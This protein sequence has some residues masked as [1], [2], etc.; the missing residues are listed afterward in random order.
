[1]TTQTLVHKAAPAAFPKNNRTLDW[2]AHN[3]T[4]RHRF[5]RVE[6]Q[7]AYLLNDNVTGYDQSEINNL[8][9]DL[10]AI[11]TEFVRLNGGLATMFARKFDSN[12]RTQQH[13]K[14]V[15][16]RDYHASAMAGLWEAF[17]RFDPYRDSTFSTFAYQ[18]IRGSVLRTVCTT[19]FQHLSHAEFALRPQILLAHEQLVA[20]L[21][22]DVSQ[23]ELAVSTGLP[24]AKVTKILERPPATWQHPFT[25]EDPDNGQMLL[26]AFPST[27]FVE[28]EDLLEDSLEPLLGSL[29]SVELWM[30]LARSSTLGPE[31]RS[32]VEV[33]NDIGVSREVARRAET[34]A[35][36]RLAATAIADKA[37]R[38]ATSGEVADMLNIEFAI[39]ADYLESS[40]TDLQSRLLRCFK[41]LDDAPDAA[42][43]TF[44]TARFNRCGEEFVT[45]ANSLIGDAAC[46]YLAPN[47]R[48]IGVTA[49]ACKSWEAFLSWNPQVNTFNMHLQSHMAVSYKRA[50][51]MSRQK[52]LSPTVLWYT[53][54]HHSSLAPA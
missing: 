2:D 38:L 20:G 50:R 42:A 10:A 45:N 32:L 51:R 6:K 11:G 22:R 36:V 24:L 37:G 9:S 49:A 12:L 3:T 1:M 7:L 35:R 41:S 33:G 54:R 23:D 34:R 52:S 31:T 25:Y 8:Q 13:G 29:N 18:F 14:Y 39:A 26:E 17:L 15:N 53:I 47:G 44:A 30:F 46:R 5:L 21:G 28:P 43:R 16:E 48:P 19:E 27:N 40:Y 4:L